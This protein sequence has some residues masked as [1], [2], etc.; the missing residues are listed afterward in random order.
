MNTTKKIIIYCGCIIV[1]FLLL[2]LA[3]SLPDEPIYQHVRESVSQLE[4]EGI[5]PQVYE[6]FVESQLDNFTDALMLNIASDT[7]YSSNALIAAAAN[8]YHTYDGESVISWLT[9][10]EEE[11]GEA[12]VISYARYWHGYLVILRPLLIIF[13][14][15]EIR[16]INYIVQV[17]L[18]MILFCTIV[19]KG[20][21]NLHYPFLQH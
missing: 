11:S 7:T 19:S 6:G 2:V 15:Q 4:T 21:N 12:S 5:H 13:N 9:V 14:Y 20:K 8:C 16:I 10:N 1:G 3:Y 18:I 17:L